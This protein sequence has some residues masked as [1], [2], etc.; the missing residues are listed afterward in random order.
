MICSLRP[1]LALLFVSSCIAGTACS[2]GPA[3]DFDGDWLWVSSFGGYF[4]AETWYPDPGHVMV[5]TLAR[6]QYRIETNQQT[7]LFPPR[8][9]E[10]A[11]TEFEGQYA[12]LDT[13]ITSTHGHVGR[14]M[15]M[16][17][18]APDR[19]ELTWIPELR[20]DTLVLHC[21]M[22]DGSDYIFVRRD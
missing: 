7:D 1:R 18:P 14:P 22:D 13:V 19:P 8:P 5:L 6:G 4:T 2:R 17:A 11:E 3:S 20:G 16:S 21:Y 15:R 9:F 12:L 10:Q